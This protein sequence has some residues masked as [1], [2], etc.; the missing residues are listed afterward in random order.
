MKNSGKKKIKAIISPTKGRIANFW[1]EDRNLSVFLFLLILVMFILGPMAQVHPFAKV[2]F[3]AFFGLIL[4]S[5]VAGVFHSS[6][7][8]AAAFVVVIG[9]LVVG[10]LKTATGA[11]WATGLD[12]S[13]SILFLLLF[14]VVL[15]HRVFFDG[16]SN[17][18]RVQGAI[19]T[20][21]VIAFLWGHIYTLILFLIPGSFT[22]NSLP[23]HGEDVI[24]TM[25]YFSSVTITTAGFGDVLP[26]HP[27]AQSF[28]TLEAYI[29]ILFPSIMIARLVS[30]MMQEGSSNT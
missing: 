26:V 14:A 13:L 23:L 8:R 27:I 5:G 9:S 12:L 20:F 3:S 22:S 17:V 6:A 29:G 19:A 24:N 16:T 10:E 30:L 1:N 15:L 7:A 28:V 2:A 18:H 21:L 4:I 11:N 25:V